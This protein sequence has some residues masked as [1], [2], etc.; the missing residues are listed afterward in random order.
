LFGSNLGILFYDVT[1]L[2]FKTTNKDELRESGF[3]KNGKNANS[4]IVLGLLVSCG[5]YPLSYSLF[6]GSQY[7]GYV[8]LPIVDD[9]VQ[10][11]NLGKDFVVIADSGLM[12]AKNIKLLRDGEYKY[13][14]RY[15]D[16]ERIWP[17]DGENNCN[18][19][20]VWSIQ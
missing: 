20:S 2:Y 10:R 6:N 17:D 1:T 5:G 11:F 13:I 14:N 16:K 3:S 9:F 12:S 7:E 15:Q 18:R 8:M 19:A 4:Q